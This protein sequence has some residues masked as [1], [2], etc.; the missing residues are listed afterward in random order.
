MIIDIA[1][2]L[3]LFDIVP[4]VLYVPLGRLGN[5]ALAMIDTQDAD[6]LRYR[7]RLTA[8]Y[9]AGSVGLMHRVIM[10]RMLRADI[11]DGLMVDHRNGDRRDNR[12]ANLRLADR[13]Q[14]AQNRRLHANNTSG[15]PGVTKQGHKWTAR[16]SAYGRRIGLGS[17]DTPEAAYVAYCEAAQAYHGAFSRLQTDAQPLTVGSQAQAA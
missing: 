9:A 8:G 6:L 17:F 11:P 7:W 10:C 15:Y 14:N 2:P 13:Y 12:R 4:G 16:I 5:A 3:T 1:Q